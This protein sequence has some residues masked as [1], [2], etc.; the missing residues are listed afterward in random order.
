MRLLILL[1]CVP[2]LAQ[3]PECAQ[4]TIG[5]APNANGAVDLSL[6]T[7]GE[8]ARFDWDRVVRA[9]LP[10]D[11][12]VHEAERTAF[13]G[14]CPQMLSAKN[15]QVDGWLALAPLVVALHQAG[16]STVHLFVNVKRGAAEPPSPSAGWQVMQAG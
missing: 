15:G 1:F 8:G 6:Y 11:W 5:A 9:V 7:S 16:Y 10:C 4:A 3:V 14:T 13:S 12:E 2:L